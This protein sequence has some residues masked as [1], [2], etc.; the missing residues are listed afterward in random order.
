MDD[1]P[2]RNGTGPSTV[3]EVHRVPAHRRRW[4]R[5]A[6]FGG[7][8][9]GAALFTWLHDLAG[10]DIAAATAHA[11]ALQSV[12]RALGVNVESA[13]NHWLAASPALSVAAVWY[14][15]LYYL[16]F[17]GVLLWVLL[18]HAD[19]YR[20]V[21]NTMIVM[22]ALALVIFWL[23]PMS[24]PRFALPGIVDIVAQ[25]DIIAGAASRDLSNGQ[26]HFSAFPSMHVGWSALSA[27]AAWLVLRR[28]HPRAGLLVWLYPAAMVG[29]VITTGNHYVLDVVGTAVLFAAAIAAAAVLPAMVAGWHRPR[30]GSTPYRSS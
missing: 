15:R 28:R 25:R 1:A 5:L 7:L 11:H 21:R 23:L 17:I 3:G 13:A 27:Y 8:V 30:D 16:P 18:R 19:D 9:V 6:E 22:A 20:T 14:Y 10:T 26:N 4:R 24:P 2:P 12:E 29:V